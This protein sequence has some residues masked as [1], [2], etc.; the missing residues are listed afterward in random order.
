MS[1]RFPMRACSAAVTSAMS[2]AAFTYMVWPG[3]YPKIIIHKVGPDLD[4]FA[5]MI[6]FLGPI[7]GGLLTIWARPTEP[8]LA[9]RIAGFLALAS[10]LCLICPLTFLR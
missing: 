9:V 5:V 7:A 6:W 8:K 2:L 4:D 10:L 3:R 1:A